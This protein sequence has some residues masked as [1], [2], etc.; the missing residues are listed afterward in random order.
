MGLPHGSKF[1]VLA[2]IVRGRKGEYRDVFA[3]LRAKVTC[4]CAWMDRSYPWKIRLSW[5]DEEAH[6]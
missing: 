2:P 5:P 3:D 6:D 1:A 4:G